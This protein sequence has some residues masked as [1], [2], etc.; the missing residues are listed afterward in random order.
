VKPRQIFFATILGL[1]QMMTGAIAQTTTSSQPPEIKFRSVPDPLRLPEGMNFGEAAGVAV[2]PNGHV[3]VFSRGGN[4]GGDAFG[5]SEAQLLE[6]D[7][8]GDYI[9]EIGKGLYGFAYAHGVRVDSEGNI[10]ATDKGTDEVIKFDPNGHVLMVLGRRQEAADGMKPHS[11]EKPYKPAVDGYF[12]QP[13]N[14][15]WD[16]DGNIYVSDGYVNA[17]VAKLDKDGNWLMS[18]G[19]H[20]SGPGQFDLVHDIAIDAKGEVYVADRNNRRVQVFD[21]Q[22]KYLREIVINVPVPA[23]AKPAIGPKIPSSNGLKSGAP[24]AICITPNQTLFVADAF[25]GRIYRLTLDGKVTGYLGSSGKTLGHFG[26]VHSLACPSDN[27]I[28][29][30]ELLNWRVQKLE[31]ED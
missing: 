7:A 10:W 9:R 23:D 30:A 11:R 19:D 8:K 25:P 29:A 6:F 24:W 28:W 13:T 22:G 20:G 27:V 12:R 18:W 3:F 5:A 4:S 15:A 17:R 26:W 1:S 31:L 14:V 21:E 2:G 16:K